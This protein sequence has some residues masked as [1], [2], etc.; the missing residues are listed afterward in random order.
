MRAGM[1]MGWLGVG[2]RNRHRNW[3]PCM[4]VIDRGTIRRGRGE[5]C[6]VWAER[7]GNWPW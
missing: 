2:L 3:N 6:T 5:R 4:Q 7:R 1:G